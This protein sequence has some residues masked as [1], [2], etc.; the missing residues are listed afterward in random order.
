MLAFLAV[1]GPGFITANV[2]NDPGGIST[3]SQ[4][5]AEFG[6][7]LALEL[8]PITIALIVVQ[9]MAARM[10]A[11]TGKGL[12][13]SDSGRIR[14]ACHLLHH[15]RA[16]LGRLHEH[17]RR[18]LR[19][20]RPAW[21]SSASASTSSVPLGA[22]LVWTSSC[23]GGYK[24][25]ER[26]LLIASLVYFAY[27]DVRISG[28]TGLALAFKQT[29]IPTLST[30]TRDTW[31]AG[32]PDRHHDHAMDAVLPA[33]GCGGEGRRHAALWPVPPGCY[34]RLRLH[35]RSGV[36]HRRGLRSDHLITRIEPQN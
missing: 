22:A 12:V 2:D 18:N 29:F 25:V 32:R 4:A 14:P 27:P 21:G 1:L 30:D 31:S 15:G 36:L 6:Y 26:I 24:P 3:Y 11:V 35:R 17:R 20:S 13:G 33:G 7:Q 19:G 10:G 34:Y 5:G 28:K 9:E 16:R 23:R 8:I